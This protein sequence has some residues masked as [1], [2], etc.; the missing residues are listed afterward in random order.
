M[1]EC[2][3]LRVPSLT[4]DEVRHIAT[5]ARLELN[6]LEVERLTIELAAILEYAAQVQGVDTATVRAGD[7][8]EPASRTAAVPADTA[9][10]A[11]VLVPSLPRNHVL[12]SDTGFFTVP[13]VLGG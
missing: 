9:L 7:A 2:Y 8:E 13:R 1:I 12:D 6:E 4:A 5:L 10:R 11:D 3:D